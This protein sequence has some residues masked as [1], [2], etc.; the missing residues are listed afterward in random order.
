MVKFAE[1]LESQAVPVWTSHYMSYNRLK[2]CLEK[3]VFL[4]TNL[5]KIQSINHKTP[6]VPDGDSDDETITST[7][8]SNTQSTFDKIK[9]SHRIGRLSSVESKERL[10]VLS[11]SSTFH[12]D[13]T[14]PEG[15][16]RA[17]S[18]K[19]SSSNTNTTIKSNVSPQEELDNESLLLPP[20]AITNLASTRKHSSD[21]T[22]SPAKVPN[23]VDFITMR[24]TSKDAEG[25]FQRVV[26]R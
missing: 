4:R 25:E 7:I 3:C 24:R 8:T 13:P 12:G 20:P 6:H 14:S 11:L 22:L 19:R 9:K 2:R 15:A 18:R 17:A 10:A 21:P 26:F 16:S 5:L 23:A 1:V